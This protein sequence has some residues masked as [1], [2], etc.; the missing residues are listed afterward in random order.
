M[1]IINIV[2]SFLQTLHIPMAINDDGRIY[3]D[4]PHNARKKQVD[5]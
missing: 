1:Q 5:A 2:L 3:P 4:T